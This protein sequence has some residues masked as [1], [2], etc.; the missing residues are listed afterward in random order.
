GLGGFLLKNPPNPTNPH[1][2]KSI[3]KPFS[4]VYIKIQI[5][6]NQRIRIE[7]RSARL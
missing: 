6:D 2:D 3:T 5:I 4:V 7:S 1:S